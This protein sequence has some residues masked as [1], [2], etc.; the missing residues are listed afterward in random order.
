MKALLR[1]GFLA[2]AALILPG[3]GWAEDFA[4]YW[5]IDDAN[6]IEFE[7]AVVYAVKTD[8][9]EGKTWNQAE[10]YGDVGAI[11]LPNDGNG[12]WAYL[13]KEGST[14]A[15]WKQL[16]DL[17]GENWSSYSFY[18]ELLQWDAVNDN[19]VRVGVSTTS[20]YGDLVTNHHILGSGLTIP[21][22]LVVWAPTTSA[23]P[24]PTTGVL[25]LLGGALLLL[26]RRA[27]AA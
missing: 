16:T 24:E 18:V 22:N 3:Q 15:T 11:G 26:R 8:S 5:M 27:D 10:G 12:G 21:S 1:G 17:G 23:V 6:E 14:T 19:E 25:F 4:L 20:T 2:L 7:Y 13:P 9:I